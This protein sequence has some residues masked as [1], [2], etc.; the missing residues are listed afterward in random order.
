MD[1]EDW[2]TQHPYQLNSLLEC[3]SWKAKKH[4]LVLF[5]V[6]VGF[7][8]DF[9]SERPSWRARQGTVSIFL[10]RFVMDTALSHGQQHDR[11]FLIRGLPGPGGGRF[12]AFHPHIQ[13]CN[14]ESFLEPQPGVCFFCSLLHNDFTN[15]LIA[16]NLSA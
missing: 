14:Q 1:I 12:A 3:R 7:L 13:F 4:Y 10:A 9:D 8:S 15:L 11:D 16:K 2:L 5:L 6:N